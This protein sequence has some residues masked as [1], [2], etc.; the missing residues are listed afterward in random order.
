L[1]F[2]INLFENIETNKWP[3]SNFTPN[4]TPKVNGRI[5][6]LTISI[7]FNKGINKLGLPFGVKCAKKDKKLKKS[8]DET[9]INHKQKANNKHILIL[10]LQVFI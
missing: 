3:V 2:F 8:L 5:E 10:D 7:I 6:I 1:I 9:I 4:R